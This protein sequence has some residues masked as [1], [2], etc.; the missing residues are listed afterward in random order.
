MEKRHLIWLKLFKRN[1]VAFVGLCMFSILIIAAFIAPLL[2]LYSPDEMNPGGRLQSPS[3]EH[4]F[5]TDRFGRDLYSRVIYGSRISLGVGVSVVIATTIFGTI[6][7]IISGYYKAVDEILMRIMDSMM[8]F[9]AIILMIAIMAVLGSSLFNVILALSIVYT[10][11]TARVVRGAVLQQKEYQYVESARSIGA[12]DL[13]I[14]VL[15]IL[16]NCMAPI[17]IQGTMIFAYSVLAESSLSFLGVGVPPEI[18]SWGNLL[19][20]G[21]IFLRRAPWITIFPGLTIALCVLSLNML[22]DG[23]RDILDPKIRKKQA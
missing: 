14:T 18:P 16:P 10:P 17:I 11:R 3:S 8:A 23:L 5:G 7:G 15:H 22:G 6:L 19:S 1:K 20:D 4:P 9:P 21:K 13:R 2:A 12:N